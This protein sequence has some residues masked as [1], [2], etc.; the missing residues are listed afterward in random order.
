MSTE[1]FWSVDASLSCTSHQEASAPLFQKGIVKIVNGDLHKIFQHLEVKIFDD[2]VQASL[3]ENCSEF[4]KFWK[5]LTF[6]SESQLQE[7]FTTLLKTIVGPSLIV[8]LERSNEDRSR[9]DIVVSECLVLDE[10]NEATKKGRPS[11]FIELKSP[12][13]FE[14]LNL[15][16]HKYQ[17]IHYVKE[18]LSRHVS[19]R[20][21]PFILFN[22]SKFYV[23]YAEWESFADLQLII[24]E[25]PVSIYNRFNHI[26]SIS[27][28]LTLVAMALLTFAM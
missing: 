20:V 2:S 24:E 6:S 13:R 18:L 21:L 25:T 9:C 8:E 7:S 4:V 3:F 17:L 10:V 26:R 27:I 14:N 11:M 15:A 28:S 1:D 12:T 19:I 23:G 22:G 16:E 5:D